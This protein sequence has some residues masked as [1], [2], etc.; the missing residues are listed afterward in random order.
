MTEEGGQWP[1]DDR[2]DRQFRPGTGRQ[3][4]PKRARRRTSN[5][6]NARIMLGVRLH[7]LD[8]DDVER[9]GKWTAASVNR[10]NAESVAFRLYDDNHQLECRWVIVERVDGLELATV[11]AAGMGARAIKW[12]SFNAAPMPDHL[13]RKNRKL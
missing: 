11:E 9:A 1:F 12:R 7:W 10:A 13:K 4:P 5:N 8:D 6:P 2:E 3:G